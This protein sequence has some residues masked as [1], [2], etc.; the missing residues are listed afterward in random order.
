MEKKDTDLKW[1]EYSLIFLLIGTL[2]IM[3]MSIGFSIGKKQGR[4]EIINSEKWIV[5]F[6]KPNSEYDYRIYF[7]VD[8][9]VYVGYGN[10]G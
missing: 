1:W 3:I 10:I 7:H 9:N 4:K 5:D 6:E 8:D 2:V